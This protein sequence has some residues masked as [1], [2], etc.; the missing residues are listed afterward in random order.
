MAVQTSKIPG[1]TPHCGNIPSR[2]AQCAQVASH[3]WPVRGTPADE[4]AQPLK[5]LLADDNQTG[6]VIGEWMLKQLGHSVETASDG[7]Q[8]LSK[9][10]TAEFDLI[11]LDLEMPRWTV[12]RLCRES[13]K[14]KR[15]RAFAELPSW[16]SP[17]MPSSRTRDAVLVA[18]HGR[19]PPEA[20]Q[21]GQTA[22][23]P[24]AFSLPWRASSDPLYLIA[25]SHWKQSEEAM[26]S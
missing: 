23:N 19:L 8:V 10:G 1:P 25:A 12:G 14:G 4:P 26:R 7:E 11:L 24:Q 5:I 16:P 20:L 13:A 17:P 6:L 21:N 22:G 3:G 9:V 2:R 15:R 18:G